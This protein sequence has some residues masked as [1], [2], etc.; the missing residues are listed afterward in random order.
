[1][2]AR[3]GLPAVS[4]YEI[5]RH[6]WLHELVRVRSMERVG[7]LNAQQ[8][9]KLKQSFQRELCKVRKMK[10]VLSTITI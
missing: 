6:W 5:G 2:S 4:P 10:N 1:M 9:F 7:S 3:G 8:A